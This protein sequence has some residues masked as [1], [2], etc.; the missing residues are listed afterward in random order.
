MSD[1]HHYRL[2]VAP[3]VGEGGELR[4]KLFVDG[5][6][7]TP[8]LVQSLDPVAL[9]EIRFG[10]MASTANG[11]WDIEFLRFAGLGLA[12]GPLAVDLDE[13]GDVDLEDFGLVQRCLSGTAVPQDDPACCAAKL[14][15]DSDVDQ[16]DVAIIVGCI[17]GAAVPPDPGCYDPS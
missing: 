4:A 8:I 3:D 2:V 17:T 6:W 14:D 9:N 13:D 11:I 16:A 5:D 1:W 10:D 12:P 15:G 7:Q